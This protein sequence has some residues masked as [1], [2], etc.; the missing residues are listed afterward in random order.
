[1]ILTLVFCLASDPAQCRM[2]ELRDVPAIVCRQG[3]QIAAA[4]WIS[5]HPDSRL[6]RV[7]CRPD[8]GEVPA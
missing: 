7:E 5:R 1:M 4:E 6:M 8:N 2:V 3:Y